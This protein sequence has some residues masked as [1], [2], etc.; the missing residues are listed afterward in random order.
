Y[1]RPAAYLTNDPSPWQVEVAMSDLAARFG[2]RGTL[3]NVAVQQAGPSGR[4]LQVVLDGSSGP[5]AVAGRSFAASLGLKSTLFTLHATTADVA[6]PPPAPG[7]VLQ[8]LPEE[9][10]QADATG[11]ADPSAGSGATPAVAHAGVS[12][13]P[14]RHDGGTSNWWLIGTLAI[15]LNVGAGGAL[16]RR[17]ISASAA[18]PRWSHSAQR[19][20]PRPAHLPSNAD[21]PTRRRWRRGRRIRDF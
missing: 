21:G 6:P 13:E 18:G 7:A 3:T 2:Y 14:L 15:V 11:P 10:A 12:T 5:K 4:A 9:A 1:L 16:L 19:P 8:G 17:R 20:G